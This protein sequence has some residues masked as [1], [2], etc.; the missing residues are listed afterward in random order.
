MEFSPQVSIKKTLN[1][2]L[3]LSTHSV[4]RP[5]HRVICCTQWLSGKGNL[6]RG[7]WS[8]KCDLCLCADNSYHSRYTIG[9]PLKQCFPALRRTSGRQRMFGPRFD[10]P[11]LNHRSRLDW[12]T[13]PLVSSRCSMG[14][15]GRITGMREEDVAYNRGASIKLY[16]H[17]KG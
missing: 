2:V 3:F 16:F 9:D 13:K 10:T 12:F 7:L 8:C 6:K 14:K 17:L 11:P 4:S 1:A 5:L 15:P